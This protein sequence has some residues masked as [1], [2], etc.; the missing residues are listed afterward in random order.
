MTDQMRCV[1]GPAALAAVK[2][3]MTPCQCGHVMLEHD[4]A[5]PRTKRKGV[6]TECLTT[7]RSGKCGCTIYVPAIEAAGP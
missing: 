4:L 7:E 3:W 2:L 1:G 5:D 6:R